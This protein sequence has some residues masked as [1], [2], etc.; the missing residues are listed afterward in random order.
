[1]RRSSRLCN[2]ESTQGLTFEPD[3]LFFLSGTEW[4]CFKYPTP[5]LPLSFNTERCNPGHS[6]QRA[7]P[8]RRSEIY[9]W[10]DVCKIVLGFFF[11]LC[12][13][14]KNK[15]KPSVF[16]AFLCGSGQHDEMQVILSQFRLCAHGTIKCIPCVPFVC[17]VHIMFSSSKWQSSLPPQFNL[18]TP[19][20]HAK[21]MTTS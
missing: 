12:W 7:N 2:A 13:I 16:T 4:T 9:F 14:F 17:V 20:L 8:I 3:H 18:D 21:K 10:V 5:G 6:C 19:N 15:T 11:L 1:M